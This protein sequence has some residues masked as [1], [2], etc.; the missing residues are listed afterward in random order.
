MLWECQE[1]RNMRE[2]S[3][4]RTKTGGYKMDCHMRAE[5][6]MAQ[7]PKI[8]KSKVGEAFM[9]PPTK[10]EERPLGRIAGERAMKTLIF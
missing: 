7:R 10:G 8:R 9:R 2:A 4:R 3:M 5:E 6:R 1:K